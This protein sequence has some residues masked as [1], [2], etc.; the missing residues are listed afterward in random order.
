MMLKK[1]TKKIKEKNP[2][3]PEATKHLKQSQQRITF[4][5]DN[6]LI[7]KSGKDGTTG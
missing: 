7:R 5:D 1:K 2:F 6:Q 4:W 3:F